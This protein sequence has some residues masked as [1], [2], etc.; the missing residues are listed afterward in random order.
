MKIT[1]PISKR[2]LLCCISAFAVVSLNGCAALWD[3]GNQGALE[4][5][6]LSTIEKTG[7]KIDHADCHMI[8]KTRSAV[9]DFDAS[10]EQINEIVRGLG[11]VEAKEGEF[12]LDLELSNASGA[13][14]SE[15][16]KNPQVKAYALRG[17]PGVLKLPGGGQFEYFHLFHVA[18]TKRSSS[19]VSYASG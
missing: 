6:F 18:G 7:V 13:L 2:F 12:K 4:K 15:F 19:C 1:N 17:R 8:D 9:C 3:L 5:D 14:G 11:L 10:D 16:G